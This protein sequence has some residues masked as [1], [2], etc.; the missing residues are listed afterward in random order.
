MLLPFNGG[1]DEYDGNDAQNAA[2]PSIYVSEDVHCNDWTFE[3]AGNAS[4]PVP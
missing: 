4:D 1:D 3:I 2:S